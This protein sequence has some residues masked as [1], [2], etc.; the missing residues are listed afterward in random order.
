MKATLLAVILLL[1]VPSFSAASDAVP[2]LEYFESVSRELEIPKAVTLAIAGIESGLNPWSLNIEGRPYRFSSKE[3]ALAKA[4]E[5][6]RKG[7]S[8]DVGI[9]Q[10]NRWWLD[11]YGISLEAAFDPLANIYFG[12]WILK[13][14]IA[15]HKNIRAAIGAYHSPNPIRANRYA[16]K[17]MKALESGPVKAI[18]K[19]SSPSARPPVAPNAGRTIPARSQ[20]LKVGYDFEPSMKVRTRK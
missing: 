7:R 2:Y 16:A 1:G 13:G 14:E 18:P 8:F 10:I 4:R 17:V 5:A 11:R 15:R 12:G 20:T 6:Q 3:E 9:M 19:R